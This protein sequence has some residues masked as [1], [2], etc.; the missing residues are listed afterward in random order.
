[1]GSRTIGSLIVKLGFDPKEVDAGLK[2]FEKNLKET[3]RRMESVGRAMSIGFTAPFVLGMRQAIKAFDEEATAVRK[4]EVALGRTSTALLA[5]AAAIQKTTIYADDAV[6]NIQAYAAALG[7]SEAETQKMTQAAVNLAAGL[8]ISLD[9]AMEMLHKSTLGAAKGLGNLIPGV[10]DL[11]KEQLKSGAAID[12]VNVKF[13]GY[14]ET[15]AKTGAGPLKQFENRFGDLMEQFGEAALP[16]LNKIIEKFEKLTDWFSKL[17]PATK[18]LVVQVGAFVALGGPM[19]YMAGNIIKTADALWKLV[20]ARKALAAIGMGGGSAAGTA[21]LAGAAGSAYL[22]HNYHPLG[23]NFAKNLGDMVMSATGAQYPSSMVNQ[24]LGLIPGM[25]EA[26]NTGFL[27]PPASTRHEIENLTKATVDYANAAKH[28]LQWQTRLLTPNR[29]NPAAGMSSIQPNTSPAIAGNV[30]GGLAPLA[31]VGGHGQ[32]IADIMNIKP[33]LTANIQGHE[34][35]VR[36]L[37]DGYMQLGSTIAGVMTSVADS[38]MNGAD[39]W[40]AFGRAALAAGAQTVKAMLAATLAKAV[41]QEAGTKGVLGI[42]IGATAGIA[43]IGIVEGLIGKMKTPKLAQGGVIQG[44]T[45]ALMGDNQ[46]GKEMALPW[47]KTR[48]FAGMISQF[49]GGGGQSVVGVIRGNDIH[50]V[51]AKEQGFAARR[52]SGNVITF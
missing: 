16:L 17:S 39:A 35:S 24:N 15:L 13:K 30:G 31:G 3:G 40:G 26:Q 29:G 11:T 47:E 37:T 41:A 33:D 36:S 9:S 10:K 6:I 12:M 45:M 48:E 14:A 25:P 52:G 20:A 43:A 51:T 2:R 19:L 21:V 34:Q 27:A 8:G 4:L 23:G 1:M 22:T 46:S 5:Q 7:H 42:I 49:M 44:P 32:A 28:A 38:L 50:L 18:E